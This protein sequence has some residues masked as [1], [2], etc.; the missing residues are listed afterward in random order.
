VLPLVIFYSAFEYIKDFL[1][2]YWNGYRIVR[3]EELAPQKA[4][5]KSEATSDKIITEEKAT[6]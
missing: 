3:K 2:L 4:P 1:M 6:Q 5:E